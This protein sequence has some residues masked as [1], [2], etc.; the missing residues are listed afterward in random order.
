MTIKEEIYQL[1]VEH[2]NERLQTIEQTIQSHQKALTSETKSSAGDKH[3]TG[4][5]MLQLE[6]EKAGQQL[7]S[8]QQIKETLARIDLSKT[9]EVIS[10]GSLVETNL[11]T[12]FLSV[13]AGQLVVNNKMYFAI[14]T[15]SP[16]GKLLLG[17]TVG[18]EIL[19]NGRKIQVQNI[20]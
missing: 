3:E 13:S 11:A 4:R 18:E 8:I 10:L 15:A 20:S 5:A 19:W 17:K 2:V 6:M 14:S 16:I 1:C 12:Y 9:S 7:Q